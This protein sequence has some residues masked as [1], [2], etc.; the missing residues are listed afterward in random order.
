M[1]FV[2]EGAESFGFL[3]RIEEALG[4]AARHLNFRAQAQER[5]LFRYHMHPLP[6]EIA[7]TIEVTRNHRDA[8]G[9]LVFGPG[10]EEAL[11]TPLEEIF[12]ADLAVAHRHRAIG[13]GEPSR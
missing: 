7:A 8:D 6:T 13:I 4:S 5:A 2:R 12:R 1:S 3:L 10:F 9:A 11:Y